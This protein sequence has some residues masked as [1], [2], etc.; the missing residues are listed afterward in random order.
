MAIFNSSSFSLKFIRNYLAKSM[1]KNPSIPSF[2]SSSSSTIASVRI[3]PSSKSK[4]VAYAS[5]VGFTVDSKMAQTLLKMFVI[6]APLGMMLDNYHGLFNVLSYA[7]NGLSLIL[8][9]YDHVFLKTALWVPVLFGFAGVV[10]SYIV[11][12]LDQLFSSSSNDKLTTPQA[13]PSWPFI[14]YGISYFSAQ[15]YMSGLLDYSLTATD[16]PV[17]IHAYLAATTVIGILLFDR[18]AAGLLLAGLT[19]LAGPVAEIFIINVFHAYQYTHADWFGIC[20]WIPWIY[21]TG[22]PAVGNLA[23]RIYSSNSEA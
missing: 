13:S 11:L 23:R 4:T 20:S 17:A 5:N 21:A 10:M 14:F 3:R 8:G 1:T 18:S 6:S 16:G 19:A 7:D 15:Y 2:S 12:K 9:S 22:A